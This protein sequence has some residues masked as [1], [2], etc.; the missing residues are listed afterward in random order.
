MSPQRLALDLQAARDENA[1]SKQIIDKLFK[2]VDRQNAE[3]DQLRTAKRQESD[4]RLEA[5][6]ALDETRDRLRLA[7]DAAGLALWDWKVASPEV[8]HTARWGEMIEGLA[9]EGSWI[10]ND[11]LA[12]VHPDDRAT[13]DAFLRVLRED[14]SSIAPQVVQYRIRTSRGWLFVET[15][16]MA[17]E[18]DAQG[19]VVRLIGTHA[20]ISQ[21]K[22]QEGELKRARARAEEASK[23][24]GNFLAKISHEIRT[25][26]N[27][28]MGLT[29][30]LM[31]SQLNPQQQRWLSLIDRSSQDLLDLLNHVLDLARIES[32]KV[33]IESVRFDL[34]G[35]L[36]GLSE[37]YQEQARQRS[38]RFELEL[39]S[40]L[41]QYLEGDQ[42]RLRQVLTNLISNAIKFTPTGGQIRLMA[43]TVV[44]AME[45]ERVF[46]R[47]R[48]RDTGI[49]IAPSLH[50]TIFDEFVQADTTISQ[51]YG[52]TGLGLAIS[53]KLTRLM[54]GD[55]ALDSAL[56]QGSTFTVTLPLSGGPQESG[57]V[58]LVQA[59]D[60]A[61]SVSKSLA[62]ERFKGLQ[63]LTADDHPINELLMQEL[64]S[65]LGCEVLVARDGHQAV[66]QWERSG[67]R[68]VLM[69]VQMPDMN[70]LQATQ[71]I[72]QAE[73]RQPSR[74]RTWVIGVTANVT[75][76][77]RERCLGAGMDGYVSKPI[78]PA[79]L[80]E[81]MTAAVEAFA[82]EARPTAPSS[83]TSPPG[84][85]PAE[86]LS[87]SALVRELFTPARL[88]QELS[89]D[90]PLRLS[91]LQQ[92]SSRK[93]ASEALAQCHLL[94]GTLG[95]VDAPRG[96]R[97]VKGLE[98]AAQSGDWTLFAKVVGLLE[99]EFQ[100]LLSPNRSA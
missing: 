78:R 34:H 15:Y 9:R 50:A 25:P 96:L 58:S 21:R 14:V 90:L 32:G 48:V 74:P 4:F 7:V 56:G 19:K 62:T 37:L 41:P 67:V 80:V 20:D 57:D 71:A 1:K 97:L 44:N 51:H 35:L 26:L 63:V 59:A 52:G 73:A 55:I 47:L 54:G 89:R 13:V 77:D 79:A 87:A 40:E 65:R 61:P 83:F 45:T 93:S 38:L 72:R 98:M 3:I 53:A 39:A 2:E 75:A 22:Q 100:A 24:K 85:Q 12:R 84:G 64:L 6:D 16:G 49:G 86:P 92:A 76:G 11:L 36:D 43:D 60:S 8:F 29:H 95:W 94:R 68:L 18:R 30:L 46:V 42:V 28:L 82:S 70:G 81:A 66:A 5:E 17:T 99:T 88:H 69:D 31:D 33:H 23:V 27:A 10:F 91:L